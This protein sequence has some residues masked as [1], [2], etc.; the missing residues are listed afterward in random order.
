MPRGRRRVVVTGLGAVSPLGR[1]VRRTWE[2]CCAGRSGVR[3][4]TLFNVDKWP[5]K[6]GGEVA[7]FHLAAHLHPSLQDLVPL[8]PRGAQF[9]TVAATMAMRDSGL[10]R[11]EVPPHRIGVSVGG[12]NRSAA[13]SEM[14]EWRRLEQA[15]DP[16]R[17]H[18]IDSRM[19]LWMSQVAGV[20]AICN[21]WRCG[22]PY[23]VT[24]AACASGTMS[25]GVALKAIRRGDADVM[26]AGG[27]DSMIDDTTSMSFALLGALSK[28]NDE[29]ERASRPFDNRRDGFVLGEGAAILVFEEL[30]HALD[31][32][33]K[34]Y[35]EV[36]GYATSMTSEHIT[37]TSPDGRHPA[38]A[39]SLA[40]QD[41]GLELEQVHYINAHGTSTRANDT[42]ESLAIRK[43]FG[44]HADRLAVSSTKSMMG[45]L[46]HAAGAIEGLIT[47]LAIRDQIAPP[48]I[49]LEEPDPECDLDYVPNVAR[50]MPIEAAISNSFA[51][52]GNNATIVFRRFASG[53]DP[54]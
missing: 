7:D 32:G 27:F 45:H 52:A 53:E 43:T 47:V 37:D 35:A 29:P 33:A 5:V 21:P 26:L 4:V 17:Y 23:F 51:F 14:N 6:I 30:E 11:D 13:L 46:L 2:G 48:T 15:F 24:S 39:M 41:A 16:P 36:A 12:L 10:D 8:L 54:A 3:R 19:D 22:G 9:G 42:S 49:N 34:I 31:R 44:P 1:D 20:R 18:P 50:P 25:L 40:L 28:R 38:R